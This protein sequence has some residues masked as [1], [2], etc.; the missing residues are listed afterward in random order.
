MQNIIGEKNYIQIIKEIEQK[1]E[2]K[3]RLRLRLLK[4]KEI[5]EIKN[6]VKMQN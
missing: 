4:E 1:K 2:K 5:S 3:T 6:L